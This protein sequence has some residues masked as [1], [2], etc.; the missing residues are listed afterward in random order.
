ME[1]KIKTELPQKANQAEIDLQWIFINIFLHWKWFLIS[2]LICLP[3][4]YLKLRY[5]TSVYQIEAK[6]TLQNSQEDA[7]NSEFAVFRNM[8]LIKA[9]N[10][11][12]SQMEI[13]RS[14]N[15]MEDVVQQMGFYISY[16]IKGRLKDTELYGAENTPVEVFLN[17][18][19]AR[20]ISG[21]VYMQFRLGAGNAIRV[22]GRYGEEVFS[23]Q[24]APILDSVQI[25]VGTIYFH[26]N[27]NIPLKE[28]YNLD[29]YIYN[30]SSIARS[31][32]SRLSL[33][34][35][36]ENTS[37][38]KLT[39]QDILPQ[40]GID[41]LNKLIDTYN[42]DAMED[43]NKAA[44]NALKFIEERL[45]YVNEDLNSS[46]EDIEEF[47]R[48][49]RFIT[50]LSG[51][52]E[53]FL[54]E[55]N[56][57]EKHLIQINLQ[58]EL[59][60]ILSDDIHMRKN[61]NASLIVNPGLEDA[62]L[63]SYI[64]QYNALALERERLT[65]Y[66]VAGNP[67]V[68]K[69]EEN[70][71]SAK[72]AI[73]AA[74]SGYQRSLKIKEKD[75]KK[76]NSKS[77]EQVEKFPRLEREWAEKLRQ[78]KI[79]ETLYVALLERKEETALSL[80]VTAPGAKTIESPLTMGIVSPNRMSV[81]LSALLIGLLIPLLLIGIKT[82]FNYRIEN[83]SDVS[84]LS[85]VP[86]ISTLPLDKK[87]KPVVVSA[88]ATTPIVEMFRLIRG[89]LQFLLDTPET[90]KKVILVTSFISGEGK[91][92]V[93]INLALTFALR[94][95]TVLIG[96]DIRKPKLSSYMELENTRTGVVSYLTEQTTNIDEIIQPSKLHEQLD[97]I[98]A[99]IIPPN[100]NELLM[101]KNLDKM[102]SE[103]RTRYEYII[104]DTSPVGSV[105]DTFLLNRIADISLFV[106]RNGY[107]PKI[108]LRMLNDINRER[109]LND[110]QILVNGV[111]GNKVGKYGYSRY[112]Y[113]YGYGYSS[114]QKENDNDNEIAD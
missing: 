12:A 64:N 40:R 111:A 32:L 65:N 104:V 78:Q 61:D 108:A 112:G 72:E 21:T 51:E 35:T 86:I 77:E 8:G 30:P 87:K 109:R 9:N 43:K 90:G 91:T 95:K 47:K 20:K 57:Y 45:A 84:H 38:V 39:V 11:I 105:S 82:I 49:H 101:E 1:N 107:S 110:P 58:S 36:L 50:N 89:K 15:L 100:P 73:I 23:K 63:I 66:N 70:I 79:K 99:G 27:E 3:A 26:I 52:S 37:I 92:F 4:G 46:E 29:A 76:M 22:D 16:G 13:F 24:V 69:V 114:K 14:R 81:M 59:L 88:H 10:S 60:K 93:S 34:N 80:A 106:V 62:P 28:E 53:R 71:A 41:F 98:V 97:V 2:L 54:S 75:L 74:I 7:G 48:D 67:S 18:E 19:S 6:V 5:S 85:E 68:I 103:L 83:E 94:Y 113:G 31:Y 55:G 96:L 17:A 33:E 102:F 56:D 25:S 42:H 44:R